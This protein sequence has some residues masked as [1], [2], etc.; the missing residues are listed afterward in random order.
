MKV[1]YMAMAVAL[2]CV[3]PAHSMSMQELQNTSRFEM[4]HGFGESGNGDGTFIDKDSIK[5][6]NGLNGTKQIALT[7]YVLM[8]AGDIIQEK[9]VLYTFNT[10]QS[11]ANLIKKL[12]AHQLAS[13]KDIWLSKQKNAG[14]SSSI[15]DF[16]EYHIDGNRYDTQSEARD[17]RMATAPVDFGFAGYLLANRLYERVYGVQFDDVVAK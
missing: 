3:V 7:Q 10:K 17:R 13:Y 16:K 15:T 14:V 12:D 4:I 11:F 9:Q 5:A 8:P 6:S 1:L 2:S